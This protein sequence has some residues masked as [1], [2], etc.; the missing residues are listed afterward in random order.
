MPEPRG[1]S[2]MVLAGDIGGTNTNLALVRAEAGGSFRIVCKQRYSTQ[3]EQS[4]LGPLSRFLE[5]AAAVPGGGT[6]DLC[7]IS[8]AG[9]VVDGVI[10]LTNA[11]W[12]IVAADIA[13]FAG[14]PVRLINDFMAISYGVILLDPEDPEQLARLRHTDGSDPLPRPREGASLIIGAG[15]GLGVGYVNRHADARIAHPSEGG[16]IGSPVYDN[17][18]RDFH[19]WMQERVGYPPEMELCVSGQGIGNLF[20]FIMS[21]AFLPERM[22]EGYTPRRSELAAPGTSAAAIMA[23]PERERPAL[24]AQAAAEGD[25]RCRLAMEMF[26]RCYARGA[27]D[28]AA[29]FLPYGGLYLAGGIAA[30]NE[31]LFVG[32]DRFMRNF[33]TAYAKH[34]RE[35]LAKVPV[36]IV[37]DYSI[38]LIGAANA[39]LSM[40]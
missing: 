37:K 30:K 31:A 35:A 19:A 14:I 18:S 40:E 33:E 27:S 11:P 5:W 2:T 1:A 8:G 3:D 12:S 20:A 15:T 21:E 4:L 39:A 25:A 6:P 28:L 17:L 7:C 29:V 38:S 24:I 9:P 22:G 16:H 36:M 34:I 13:S 23:A 10:P 32:A 26:V